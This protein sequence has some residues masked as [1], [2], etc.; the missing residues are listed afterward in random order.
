MAVLRLVPG[1]MRF[2]DLR[3]DFEG[4]L[5]G[6]GATGVGGMVL[7]SSLCFY[8]S[9][10]CLLCFCS[11]ILGIFDTN[12]SVSSI[13]SGIYLMTIVGEESIYIF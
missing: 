9:P 4:L 2:G 3:T 8:L 13:S 10:F 11:R 12:F 6:A 7:A 5:G 1:V